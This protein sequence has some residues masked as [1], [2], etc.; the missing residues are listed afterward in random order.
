MKREGTASRNSADELAQ[1]ARPPLVEPT[2][3]PAGPLVR[4]PDWQRD[5]D[6]L[7]RALTM[8]RILRRPNGCRRPTRAVL[9]KPNVSSDLVHARTL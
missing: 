2:R 9:G 6:W 5:S 4:Q 1:V 7:V 8:Q 3:L